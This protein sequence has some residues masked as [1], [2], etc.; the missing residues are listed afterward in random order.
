MRFVQGAL[1]FV[2]TLAVVAA[3]TVV[4]FYCKQ[5]GLGPHHPIFFYLLPIA[6]VALLYGSVPAT[7]F[8]M[9]AT[10]CGAYFLYDPVYSLQ[11]TNP[12]EIGDLI[13]F[14][15]LALMAVKCAFELLRPTAKI[16]PARARYGRL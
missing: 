5:A 16:P 4:L 6:L 14:S 12:L 9:T 3:V 7:L 10:L 13:C 15:V 8:A 2:V 1:P 11:V